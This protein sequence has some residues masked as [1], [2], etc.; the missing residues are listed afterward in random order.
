MTRRIEEAV[1]VEAPAQGQPSPDQ[2]YVDVFDQVPEASS[3]AK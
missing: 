1:F 3:V 2:L